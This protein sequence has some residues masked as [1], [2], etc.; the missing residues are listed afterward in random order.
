MVFARHKGLIIKMCAFVYIIG[1]ETPKG[2]KTYVGWTN[3]LDKRLLM[4]NQ[5]KG[6]KFT[7]GL[8]WKLLYAEKYLDRSSA[9][10]REFYIK[11]DTKL[12]KS[13]LPTEAKTHHIK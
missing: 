2:W 3:D 1:T 5:G 6:A 9:M 10:S 8:R 12:R 11:R 7:R 13:V 4:H